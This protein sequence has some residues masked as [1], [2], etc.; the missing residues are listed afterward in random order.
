MKKVIKINYFIAS[1]L[2]LLYTLLWKAIVLAEQRAIDEWYKNSSSYDIYCPYEN[3]DLIV[4][5]MILLWVIVGV[6]M[7]AYPIIYIFD[8]EIFFPIR[9]ENPL[10][11]SRD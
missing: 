6:I 11:Q 5:P 1:I 7:L 8:K 2:F 9:I 3:I 4:I 10:C